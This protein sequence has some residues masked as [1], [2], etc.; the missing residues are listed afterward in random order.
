[1][2]NLMKTFGLFF[3][4]SAASASYNLYLNE[5][6]TM[7]LLGK[8]TIIGMASGKRFLRA[9][10]RHFSGA[11]RH[12]RVASMIKR[13]NLLLETLSTKQNKQLCQFFSSPRPRE[14]QVLRFKALG[15][16]LS[17]VSTLISKNRKIFICFINFYTSPMLG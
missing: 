5:H 12:R 4:F 13:E 9:L 15:P 8:L 6:E 11:A 17:N 7:R 10:N 14:K 1:M 16:I 2:G 3:I